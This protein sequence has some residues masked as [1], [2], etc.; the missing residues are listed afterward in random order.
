MSERLNHTFQFSA[1][2]IAEGAHREAEYHEARIEHWRDREARALLIVK[3]TIGAKVEEHEVTSGSR[4]SV[5]V[6]YGD[7][8]AWHEYQLAN[9]KVK[10]HRE[11]AERYRVDERIY[12]TQD[13]ANY[14]LDAEDVRHFR[15]GGEAREE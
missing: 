2:A 10:T 1:E 4:V 8:G 12:R 13:K 5:V 14:Q 9:G 15:L 7:P 6:D 11:L 3:E